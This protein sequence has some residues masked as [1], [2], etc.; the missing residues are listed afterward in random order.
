MRVAFL[1]MLL[2][3]L[4]GC[5]TI[6]FTPGEVQTSA[7][8]IVPTPA[9]MDPPTFG[10]FYDATSVI[11]VFGL[12]KLG[13]DLGMRGPLGR[14]LTADGLDISMQ[15]RTQLERELADLGLEVGHHV[16]GRSGLRTFSQYPSAKDL[17]RG[18]SMQQF[19][20]TSITYGFLAT[21]NASDYRPYVC[22]Q[23]QVLAADTHAVLYRKGFFANVS[24]MGA[25]AIKVD[26]PAGTA[27]WPNLAALQAD[28]PGASAAFKS[29]AALVAKDIAKQLQVVLP[30]DTK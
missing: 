26:V 21:T 15:V 17:P 4:A 22:V 9:A 8:Y 3:G 16:T 14:A 18:A 13:R 24:A 2:A 20:D 1:L 5:S 27:T 7:K 23:V 6:G 30:I 11:P 25:D 12:F 19:I 28:I 29:I 10:T